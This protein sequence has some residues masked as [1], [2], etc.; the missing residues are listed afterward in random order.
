MDV[1]VG[2]RQVWMRTGGDLWV[3][4]QL[5][6]CGKRRCS[7]D[8]GGKTIGGLLQN[9][10]CGNAVQLPFVDVAKQEAMRYLPL[11]YPP[12]C[13]HPCEFMAVSPCMHVA[14]RRELQLKLAWDRLSRAFEGTVCGLR[15]LT[16]VGHR[17]CPRALGPLRQPSKPGALT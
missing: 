12:C 9:E 10:L 4:G 1:I 13:S 14:R 11:M 8:F 6:H 3:N 16:T 2:V 5:E 7:I 15:Y 17:H